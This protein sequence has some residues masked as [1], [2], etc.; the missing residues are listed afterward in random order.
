MNSSEA[1]SSSDDEEIVI[2]LTKLVIQRYE[3][4]KKWF[5]RVPHSLGNIARGQCSWYRDYLCD[6]PIYSASQFRRRFR[7]P[8]SLFRRL[9]RD[10]TNQEPKLRQQRDATGKLGA[11]S[12][13]K[14]LSS[15]RRLADGCSYSS[16]DDQSRMSIESM[17]KSFKLLLKAFKGCYTHLYLN[18]AP[19]ANELSRLEAEYS[20]QL[21]PG[22]IG[23][24]DCMHLYW[25]NCPKSW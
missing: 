24:L 6:D 25:K 12:W 21:F 8:L 9:E 2:E 22:C 19:N 4:N 13:Q 11:T 18:R 10:L 5:G 3:F 7:V 23:A 1:S 14:I 15:I 17:R 16:L 20:K